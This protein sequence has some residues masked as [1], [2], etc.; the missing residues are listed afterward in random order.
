[1]QHVCQRLVLV[2]ILRTSSLGGPFL[3]PWLIH[4]QTLVGDILR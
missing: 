1:L 3:G 2:G 4:C